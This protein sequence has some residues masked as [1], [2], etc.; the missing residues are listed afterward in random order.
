MAT[1][2]DIKT[3]SL[4]LLDAVEGQECYI[5][6]Q[7]YPLTITK[8]YWC[9]C[10][11]SNGSS[12]ICCVLRRA[13]SESCCF[14]GNSVSSSAEFSATNQRLIRIE[15]LTLVRNVTKVSCVIFATEML[16]EK[17]PQ[18]EV[19]EL[20]A[21]IA[22]FLRDLVLEKGCYVRQEYMSSRGIDTIHIL[23]VPEVPD[24]HCFTLDSIHSVIEIVDVRLAMPKSLPTCTH[25]LTDSFEQPMAALEQL[26]V[27]SKRSLLAHRFPTTA[28]IV[29]PVGCG[30][31]TLLARFLQRNA[32]NCYY[33]T[34]SKVMSSQPGGTEQELRKIFQAAR[35]FKGNMRP[36]TPIVIVIEDLELLCAAS[37]NS[38]G[39][40]NNSLRIAAQLYKLIDELDPG[41]ICLATTSQPDQLHEHARRAGRFGREI[42]LE[43]PSEQERGRL[44]AAWCQEHQLPLPHGKL[45]DHLAKNT[46]GYFISD[47]N[48]LL[49]QVQKEVMLHQQPNLA[50]IYLK[51]L[52]K[53]CP[54]GSRATSVRV[55]KMTQGF[56]AIGGMDALKRKLEAS[57]IAGLQHGEAFARLGLSL[58]KGVLLYGPPGCAKTT[59]AKC[60]AKEANMTFIA[61]SA[62]EV[63]SP[64]V[65]SA[66]RYITRM[67]NTARKNA[68]CLIFLDEIDSLVGRRTVSGGGGG[69]VQLRIL[70]TLLTEMDGIVGGSNEKHILVVAATN[71]PEMIDDALLRPGRFDQLIHV[72]SPDLKS[73]LAL[74]QLHGERMPFDEQLD[75]AT[76]VLHTEGYSGADLC[77]LCNEA[78]IQTF[79][80]D[81]QA[82]KIEMQ[83][84]EKV[85][86]KLKSSLTRSQI[87]AYYKFANRSQQL[88]NK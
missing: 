47:L 44:I 66:E 40:S 76:I 65:G 24:N 62:A 39:N 53:L 74:L 73:R 86:C 55:E 88:K 35:A 32:C 64:Y 60:L 79:Q 15:S 19:E 45:L 75:L 43:M 84:F 52:K 80:R 28:L 1:K 57:V 11:L 63:Y 42:T 82:T 72:P 8:S 16:H 38:S 37:S 59:I 30:K 4:S 3:N 26:L 58:P 68:P 50:K 61:T 14:L 71:R 36:T 6:W 54:S 81:P 33:I 7:E 2:V 21:D 31:S 78:A 49:S 34:S 48:L 70:S 17:Q 22:I 23:D 83:D 56:E 87:D 10:T 46:Q 67:F 20:R 27:T 69:Q 5:P 18:L 29:G 9:R 85:M 41:I 77:N 51:C 13:G 25:Y 12:A